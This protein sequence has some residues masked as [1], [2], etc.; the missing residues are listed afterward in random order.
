MTQPIQNLREKINGIIQQ[1]YPFDIGEP[2]D[3]ILS[4]L[5]QELDKCKPEEEIVNAFTS[6]GAKKVK[7]GKNQAINEYQTNINN[8]FL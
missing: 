6:H 1:H 5:K 3:K 8:L 2:A 7:Y 4:L